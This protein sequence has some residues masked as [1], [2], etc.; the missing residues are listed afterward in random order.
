MGIKKKRGI[1]YSVAAG[2]IQNK[3]CKLMKKKKK[4]RYLYLSLT[5]FIVY[6]RNAD[7]AWA[8]SISPI[9]AL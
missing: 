7:L 2:Y 1:A 3:Q 8:L 9:V 6:S 4:K 5:F